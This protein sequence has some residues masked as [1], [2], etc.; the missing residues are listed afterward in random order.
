MDVYY[1]GLKIGSTRQSQQ[2]VYSVL[3]DPRVAV[4][5]PVKDNLT[6]PTNLQVNKSI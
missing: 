1:A 3:G 5:V 6:T 4:G 2:D